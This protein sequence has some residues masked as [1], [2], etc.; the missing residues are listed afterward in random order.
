MVKK[1]I[2]IYRKLVSCN[3]KI[4]CYRPTCLFMLVIF[5]SGFYL[6]SCS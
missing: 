3:K 1:V 5:H 4:F 6:D 2:Y